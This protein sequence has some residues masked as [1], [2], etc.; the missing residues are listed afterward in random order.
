MK[1]FTT[2]VQKGVSILIQTCATNYS[3]ISNM[4]FI[5]DKYT[6]ALFRS[7]SIL[8]KSASAILTDKGSKMIQELVDIKR[9]D[10]PYS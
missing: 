5:L 4:Y 2:V 7:M 8:H 1:H 9:D 6:R 10:D 3:T